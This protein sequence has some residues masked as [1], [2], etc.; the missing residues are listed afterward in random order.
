MDGPPL[1]EQARDL[2]K[3]HF[4]GREDQLPRP[5]PE[6]LVNHLIPRH[7]GE[8]N[9]L[10][11]TVEARAAAQA[12]LTT[13]D[14]PYHTTCGKVSTA[15]EGMIEQDPK[16]YASMCYF[17]NGQPPAPGHVENIATSLMA[18]AKERGMTQILSLIHI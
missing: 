8:E 4:S 7:H 5:A 12:P 16:F 18:A 11:Q 1:D 6:G 9:L 10:P 13:P 3:A 15:V 17:N 14:S 2:I